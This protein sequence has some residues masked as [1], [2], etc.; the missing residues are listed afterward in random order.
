MKIGNEV[1]RGARH[2]GGG[3]PAQMIRVKKSSRAIVGTNQSK[4]G[5]LWKH[6][7]HPRLERGA[8]D[9]GIVPVPG[10]ENHSRAPRPAALEVHLA[11]ISD[12]DQTG[13]ITGHGEWSGTLRCNLWRGLAFESSFTAH[14]E[15]F[16]E[17]LCGLAVGADGKGNA[18]SADSVFALRLIRERIPV[19]VLHRESLVFW[20][21]HDC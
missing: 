4:L 5:N 19:I 14:I 1:A 3:A 17:H 15:I 12:R 20:A 6:S 13:K 10:F 7:G 21:L 9:C 11:A 16:H 2:G 18:A 8:P